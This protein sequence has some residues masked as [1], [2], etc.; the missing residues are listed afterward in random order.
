MKHGKIYLLSA[1]CLCAGLVVFIIG[2]AMMGFNVLNFDTEPA[3]IEQSYTVKSNIASLKVDDENANINI[4]P[5]QDKNIHIKYYENGNKTYNITNLADGSVSVKKH[6]INGF[7]NN[8]LIISIS[9]PTLTIEVPENYGGKLYIENSGGNITAEGISLGILSVEADGG[10]IRISKTTI[11]DNLDAEADGGNIEFYE[12]DIKGTCKLA[13]DGGR[14]FMQ[15]VTGSDLY[16]E[17]DGGLLTMVNTDI[18]ESI[19]AETDGGNIEISSVQFGNGMTLIA[20]GGNV[21]GSVVGS[22]ED[23]TYNCIANGGSCN[24]QNDSAS[25]P[26]QL[27]IRTSGGNIEINFVTPSPAVTQ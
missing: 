18:K 23:F 10:D 24:L 4:R 20:D 12:S 15:S 14:L 21:R 26:K 11:L 22:A 13:C 5:S 27:N 19:F 3:Y 1:V 9:T 7:F 8:F 2:F 6:T 25:G 16:A 17:T